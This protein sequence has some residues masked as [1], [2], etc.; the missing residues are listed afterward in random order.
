MKI[1]CSKCGFEFESPAQKAG[2]VEFSKCKSV[3]RVDYRLKLPCPECKTILG[4]E[5]K[6]PNKE[7]VIGMAIDYLPEQT[8]V[9]VDPTQAKEKYKRYAQ[10]VQSDQYNSLIGTKKVSE[11]KALLDIRIKSKKKRRTR[12]SMEVETFA[13]AQTEM[14]AFAQ[15]PRS[16]EPVLGTLEIRGLKAKR[17]PQG[18]VLTEK[19]K[20]A[21][22][23]ASLTILTIVTS[24]TALMTRKSIEQKTLKNEVKE[25]AIKSFEESQLQE[26]KSVDDALGGPVNF[27]DLQETKDLQTLTPTVHSSIALLHI[28]ELKKLTSSYGLRLDPF[29]RRLAFHGGLDFKGKR[30]DTVESALDGKVSFAGRNG[31]Y[32]KV[33]I[34]K[35]QNGYETRYAHLDS[36][37]VEV[38]AKVQKGDRIGAIGSTGRSTGP[39]LHFELRKNGKKLDPLQAEVKIKP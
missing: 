21:I 22:L 16:S 15:L 7:T 36:I 19:T 12:T 9:F 13:D 38:G 8:Q 5:Q 3:F 32:G 31:N 23:V 37:N 2:S 39:H 30:G 20:Q 29:T 33:V 18:V 24:V 1:Q 6:L 27:S 17:S 4:L 11:E 14:K 25:H 35:H 26:Q 34:I 10:K 28:P